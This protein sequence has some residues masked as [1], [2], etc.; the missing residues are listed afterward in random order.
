MK[1][2]IIRF[3]TIVMLLSLSLLYS[4]GSSS[5]SE[6]EQEINDSIKLEQERREILDRADKILENSGNDTVPDESVP[7]DQ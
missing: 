6:R 2:I 4:C 1:T 3:S 5:Q 7:S